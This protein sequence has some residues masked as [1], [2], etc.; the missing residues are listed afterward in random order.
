MTSHIIFGLCIF[1]LEYLNFGFGKYG[2]FMGNTKYK[3]IFAYE[4]TV[5]TKSIP[6][7]S[8]RVDFLGMF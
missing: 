8:D 6:L 1:L 2:H 4:F 5:W 3:T 7:D